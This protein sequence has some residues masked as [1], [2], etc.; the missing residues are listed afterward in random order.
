MLRFYGLTMLHE[1][2]AKQ[3]KDREGV[4]DVCVYMC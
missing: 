2:R 3:P 4:G 1:P